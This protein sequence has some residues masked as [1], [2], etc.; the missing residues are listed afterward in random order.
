MKYTL[1]NH[2]HTEGCIFAG[3]ISDGIYK[4]FQSYGFAEAIEDN[5][6]FN[7]VVTNYFNYVPP[8]IRFNT[9]DIV[10]PTY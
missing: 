6:D 3:E 7:L 8:P 10:R 2:G 1:S 9:Q 4:P 5:N